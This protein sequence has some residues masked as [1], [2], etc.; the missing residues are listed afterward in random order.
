MEFENALRD[1]QL[2][3]FF[4]K[5]EDSESIVENLFDVFDEDKEMMISL[6]SF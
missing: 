3:P 4:E 2:L 5:F 1:R 6:S